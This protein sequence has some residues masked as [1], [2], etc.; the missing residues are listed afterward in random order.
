MSEPEDREFFR[1]FAR[2]SLREQVE[3]KA[4]I[5]EL[6]HC[7]AEI[8]GK[9][10]DADVKE[11]LATMESRLAEARENALIGLEDLNPEVAAWL[12]DDGEPPGVPP[13]S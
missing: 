8:A 9:L 2:Y 7:L 11:L 1:D 4:E 3:L 12:A 10:G 5:L 6:K 13:A